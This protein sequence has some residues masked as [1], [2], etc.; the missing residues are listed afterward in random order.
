MLKFI[1]KRTS[2]FLKKFYVD[3]KD[4]NILKMIKV[5]REKMK[6]GLKELNVQREK[7]QDNFKGKVTE[8]N[9]FRKILMFRKKCDQNNRTKMEVYG[10]KFHDSI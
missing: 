2:E 1:E 7:C 3:R 5:Y 4:W 6:L 9:I 8:K 10:E